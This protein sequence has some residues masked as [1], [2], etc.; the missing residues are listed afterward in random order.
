MD[1]THENKSDDDVQENS[2]KSKLNKT[3]QLANGLGTV[4]RRQNLLLYDTQDS[5]ETR[6]RN[7]ITA[8]S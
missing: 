3:Y 8:L 4:K 1:K 2:A 6:M 5:I 7:Y